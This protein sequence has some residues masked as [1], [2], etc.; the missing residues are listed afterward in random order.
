[1]QSKRNKQVEEIIQTLC[2]KHQIS[3]QTM[4]EMIAEERRI[5][6]LKRRRDVTSRLRII[7]EKSTREG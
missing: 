4:Q 5:R 6:H 7:L 1:M 3:L 2:D